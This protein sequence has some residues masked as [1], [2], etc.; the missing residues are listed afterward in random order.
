MTSS[1]HDALLDKLLSRGQIDVGGA[2]LPRD[3]N[4]YERTQP[5]EETHYPL[6][7]SWRFA[8]FTYLSAFTQ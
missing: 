3:I 8:I 5:D 6:H 4:V 7:S 2:V 1:L